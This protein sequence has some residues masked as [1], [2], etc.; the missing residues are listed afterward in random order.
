MLKF[1]Y[2]LGLLCV[3]AAYAG[4][5]VPAEY[6]ECRK[7]SDCTVTSSEGCGCEAGGDQVAINKSSRERWEKEHHEDV[8]C[9]DMISTHESCSKKVACVKQRCVLR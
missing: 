5:L 9:M 3:V 2:A 6:L 1:V 8:D 4:E 7:A